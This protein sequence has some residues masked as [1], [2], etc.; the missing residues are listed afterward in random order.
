MRISMISVCLLAIMV[1]GCASTESVK[2]AK[3]EGES[4]VYQYAYNTVFDAV[5]AA[6]KSKELEVVETDKK[7]GRILL[8]HGT[9]WMSWGEHIAVFINSVSDKTTKVEIVSKPV[10]STLNFP[11]DWQS[12][13]LNEIAVQLEAAK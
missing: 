11:P 5:L 10:M 12:I 9:T 2:L 6:A 4:R 1:G 8:S 7:E 3:G 13:L